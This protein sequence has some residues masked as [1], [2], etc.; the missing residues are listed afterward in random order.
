MYSLSENETRLI[1]A[2]YVLHEKGVISVAVDIPEYSKMLFPNGYCVK[3]Y[4]EIVPNL[5]SEGFIESSYDAPRDGPILKLTDKALE[6][7]A[8]G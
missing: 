7:F 4:N 6:V 1:N 8:N 5:V 3:K 2:M